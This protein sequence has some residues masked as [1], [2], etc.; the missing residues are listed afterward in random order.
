MRQKNEMK[1]RMED[2]LYLAIILKQNGKVI[3]E[4]FA[5]PEGAAPKAETMDTCSLCWMLNQNYT[6]KD[7]P[8]KQ[9]ALISIIFSRM[10]S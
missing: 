6:G 9:P 7:M 10:M 8:A 2:E 4:I 1:R 3:G 5:H